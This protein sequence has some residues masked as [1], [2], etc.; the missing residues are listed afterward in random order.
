[1]SIDWL[2]A[3]GQKQ[4]HDCMFVPFARIITNIITL[5]YFYVLNYSACCV[6]NFS[7]NRLYMSF[8]QSSMGSKRYK[9]GLLN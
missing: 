1:M 9:K 5:S 3:P 7:N 6:P 4:S 8:T 2:C